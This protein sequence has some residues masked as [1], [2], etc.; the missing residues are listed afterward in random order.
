MDIF[1]NTFNSLSNY[2]KTKEGVFL[3]LIFLIA[4]VVIYYS[5]KNKRLTIISMISFALLFLLNIIGVLI[6]YLLQI[7][8]T[9][10]FRMIPI[11]SVILLLSNLGVLVGFFISQKDSKSFKYSNILSEYRRDSIKQTLFLLLLSISVFLFV[12]IQIQSIVGISVLST[13]ISIWI[14]YLILRRYIND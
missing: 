1:L 6:I 10:L 5:T 9:E 14:T 2:D 3:L 4:I 8:I 12:P 13:L 11:V 7:P